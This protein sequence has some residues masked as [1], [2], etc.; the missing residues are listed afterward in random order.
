MASSTLVTVSLVMLIGA[1]AVG[2]AHLHPRRSG[3]P[4]Q[5]RENSELQ[6]SFTIQQTKNANYKE[7]SGLEAM[8][9][10]YRK[11]GVELTPELKE[12]VQINEHFV[13]SRRSSYISIPSIKPI[14]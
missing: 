7:K 14:Y 10:V 9:D 8:I 11:Y 12:A 1:H 2:G 3:R 6:G 13:A 5:P 4:T